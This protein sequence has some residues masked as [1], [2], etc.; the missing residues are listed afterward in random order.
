MRARKVRAD[1]CA[2]PTKRHSK[3]PKIQKSSVPETPISTTPTAIMETSDATMTAFG[4]TRSSRRPATIAPSAATTLAA[5]PN[6]RTLSDAIPYTL[7]ASTAPNVKTPASPSRNSALAIRN[8]TVRRSASQ[9]S[10][11]SRHRTRYDSTNPALAAPGSAALR[12][13][14]GTAKRT[15]KANTANHAAA[16]SATSRMLRPPSVV[17]PSSPRLSPSPA[18]NP[19]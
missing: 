3:R 10:F 13:S 6:S 1:D 7:T 18:M 19:R 11:R 4:P 16:R 15:G 9:R 17:S 2:G 8:Q 5:T 12:G 14:S